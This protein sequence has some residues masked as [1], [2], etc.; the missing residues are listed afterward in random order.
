MKSHRSK[1]YTLIFVLLFLS[2]CHPTHFVVG[3]GPQ[4]HRVVTQRNK[5]LLLGTIPIGTPPDPNRMSNNAA[6]YKITVKLT[7]LDVVLNVITFG[8]YS[9]LTVAVEY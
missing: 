3:E 1:F 7:F 6:D 4:Q 8:I 9:P 2:A 5:F